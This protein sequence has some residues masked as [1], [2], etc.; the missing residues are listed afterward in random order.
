MALEKLTTNI[1][2]EMTGE[3]KHYLVSAKQGDK[4]TRFINAK[5][6]NNGVDYKIPED[7][8]ARVNIKKPDGKYVYNACEFL[9]S[10][11]SIELTNQILAAA[12]TACC[13]VEIR[14]GD[15][16]QVITSASFEIEIEMSQRNE[17]AIK[18]SNEFTALEK[19]IADAKNELIEV[20]NKAKEAL[21]TQEQLNEVMEEADRISKQVLQSAKDSEKYATEAQES[22]GTAV[23]SAED[24][25]KDVENTS[26]DA[27]TSSQCAL[28][29]EAAANTASQS[30]ESSS[31]SASEAQSSAES[32]EQS[33]NRAE[34]AAATAGW[35]AFEIDA[36]GHLIYTKTENNL[37]DFQMTDGRLEVIL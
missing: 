33:A 9:G 4:A 37:I 31:Q 27:E 17:N 14:T 26:K 30:A 8:I 3:T 16:T 34:Q 29:A 19:E 12:G 13:D 28:R 6:M 36:N 15:S 20:T 32:A 5:L 10:V 11:V 22:A 18:S 23:K 35:G 2:I 25:R 1:E 7:A 24:T 21:K